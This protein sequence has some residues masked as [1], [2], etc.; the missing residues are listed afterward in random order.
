MR[1]WL[2]GWRGIGFL[3]LLLGTS[4]ILLA[5]YSPAPKPVPGPFELTFYSDSDVVFRT[6]VTGGPDETA[7]GNW[8]AQQHGTFGWRFDLNS[9]APG[10]RIQIDYKGGRV[11]LYS[12]FVLRDGSYFRTRGVTVADRM[13]YQHLRTLIQPSG[14]FRVVLNSAS[15]PKQTADV[16]PG[17]LEDELQKWTANVLQRTGWLYNRQAPLPELEIEFDGGTIDLHR[18]HIFRGND[19]DGFARE[20]PATAADTALYEKLI[21]LP[22]LQAKEGK[23]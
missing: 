2:N 7:I 10:D 15:A 11:E 23:P 3:V 21:A 14:P 18:Q 4:G 20:L 9:Y 16:A 19:G 17:V 1:K 6:T 13:L 8:L 5:S 22:E 12:T